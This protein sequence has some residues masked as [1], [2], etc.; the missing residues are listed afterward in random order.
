M[1][2]VIR[3]AL[4]RR[5]LQIEPG[6]RGELSVTIQNLSE[7]VDQYIVQVQGLNDAWL[8]LVPPRI[9]LFPQDEG[10]VTVK[11]HP[12]ER[13]RAGTYEFTVKVVSR[14][15]P[16]EFSTAQGTLDIAP[17]FLFDV[18]LTPQRKTTTGED[19]PFS[20]QLSNPG[21]TDITLQL[22]AADPEDACRYAFDTDDV[23]LEAGGSTTVPLAVAPK[24]GAGDEGRMY[25]FTVRAA[26][27]D[28]PEK[29][30]TATGELACEPQVV[31]LGLS[32]WPPKRSAVGAGSFQVQLDNRGNT[33]LDLTLQGTD[34]AEACAYRFEPPR[35][36]LQ[37]GG[38]RQVPLTVAPIGRPATDKPKLYD[39]MIRAVP[40]NAPQKAVQAAGQLECLPV[41]ISFGLDILPQERSTQSEGHFEVQI[42][43]RGQGKLSLEL[44]ASDTDEACDCR[45]GKRRV[46]LDAEET[47]TVP[48]SVKPRYKPT[49]GESRRY[50]FS[51]RA[52][53]ADAPHLAKKESGYLEVVRSKGARA[54][55]WSVIG[56]ALGNGILL[57]LLWSGA[58]PEFE[59]L[60][61]ALFGIMGAVGGLFLGLGNGKRVLPAA[62]G[63]ALG[64]V[65]GGFLVMAG[66]FEE[67]VPQALWGGF[68]GVLLGLALA[69]RWRAIVLGAAGAVALPLRVGL[70]QALWETP[71]SNLGH[72]PAALIIDVVIGSAVGL[73]FGL[74]VQFLGHWMEGP[75]TGRKRIEAEP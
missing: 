44:S 8:T 29:A 5:M 64:F 73:I 34:P 55:I 46:S 45:L 58:L 30:R 21:N 48:L 32:L 41:V 65:P 17:I 37:A 71:I 11:L 27:I 62:I 67:W 54:L 18:S 6:Q 61:F 39:F 57:P 4:S 26:P 42:V 69:Y 13:A 7:I 35:V 72:E 51:V 16:V 53:P 40:D 36:T 23:T 9:S 52:M 24:H 19:A 70:G 20:V 1:S 60:P 25:R 10:Q 38:S 14:E 33:E 50:T 66:I 68:A 3:V 2:A 59:G 56:F 31:A 63:G 15:N 49:R 12:P 43:N 22:S 47:Q 75:R 74:A 28:A